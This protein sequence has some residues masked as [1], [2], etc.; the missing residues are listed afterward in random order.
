MNKTLEYALKTELHTGGNDTLNIYTVDPSPY[1]GF[2]YYPTILS[3]PSTAIL[4][5]LMIHPATLPGGAFSGYNLGGTIVHETG[6]RSHTLYPEYPEGWTLG[7]VVVE[8]L[9]ACNRRCT[10]LMCCAALGC[11]FHHSRCIRWTL[12]MLAWAATCC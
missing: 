9:L 10:L 2:S 6:G 11:H 8:C 7:H 1:L 3:D 12:L 5:G 4:D